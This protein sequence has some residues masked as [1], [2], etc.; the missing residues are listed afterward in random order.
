MD[1]KNEESLIGWSE[2]IAIETYKETLVKGKP[3]TQDEVII[4]HSK[5]LEL[6]KKGEY[7]RD[8]EVARHLFSEREY[9]E[10]SKE[11]QEVLKGRLGERERLRRRLLKERGILEEFTE[12]GQAEKE[13][14]DK[15]VKE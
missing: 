13:N 10:E 5:T 6:L 2:A 4:I 8:E 7:Y 3:L 12:T 11:L 14:N 9:P 1:K 15:G